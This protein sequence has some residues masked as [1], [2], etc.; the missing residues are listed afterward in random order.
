MASLLRRFMTLKGTLSS[1]H[2]QEIASRGM[3]TL[4]ALECACEAL[5][6]KEQ[7][8]LQGVRDE[9][10][11]SEMWEKGDQYYQQTRQDLTN[12]RSRL[13]RGDSN[14]GLSLEDF[15]TVKFSQ[16]SCL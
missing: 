15:K 12:A 11:L 3:E 9:E 5:W 8:C 7:R 10:Q 13:E 16:R 2:R 4:N 6:T 1:E 14:F